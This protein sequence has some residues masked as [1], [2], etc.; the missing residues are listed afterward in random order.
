MLSTQALR[1]MSKEKSKGV[2]PELESFRD[3]TP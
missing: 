1:L 2:R 3:Y